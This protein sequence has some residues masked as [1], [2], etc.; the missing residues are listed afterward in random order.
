VAAAHVTEALKRCVP[1]AA[2]IPLNLLTFGRVRALRVRQ[3]ML[4]AV[5]RHYLRWFKS[6]SPLSPR[7]V[8]W[9]SDSA[10]G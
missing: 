6:G 1:T 10:K 3:A 9:H 7:S 5:L 8:H 2:A 4:L